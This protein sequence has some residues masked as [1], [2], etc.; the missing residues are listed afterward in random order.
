M[1]RYAEREGAQRNVTKPFFAPIL[2]RQLSNVTNIVQRQEVDMDAGTPLDGGSLHD[3]NLPGGVELPAQS[4]EGATLP[5]QTLIPTSVAPDQ[6]YACYR[7]LSFFPAAHHAFFRI[8]GTTPSHRTYSL[9][10]VNTSG[11]C[12]QGV[13]GINYHEDYT[14]GGVCAIM[15][16]KTESDVSSKHSL[17]PIGRYCT[18]GPNSNSYVGNILRDLGLSTAIMH[19][20]WRPGESNSPPRAGTFAHAPGWSLTTGCWPCT[21]NNY[22]AD[23][24]HGV[25]SEREQQRVPTDGGLPPGGL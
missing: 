24:M 16:G 2:Q 21:P 14:A 23:N 5:S 25:P 22:A 12:H 7:P 8:G 20:G 15:P 13:P 17:Y 11:D 10:P 3:A 4:S 1:K 18:L 9:I 19:G 6:A